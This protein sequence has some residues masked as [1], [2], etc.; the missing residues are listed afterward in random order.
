[1]WLTRKEVEVIGLMISL[2]SDAYHIAPSY[3][4]W[5]TKDRRMVSPTNPDLGTLV[6]NSRTISRNPRN[7]VR[8]LGIWIVSEKRLPTIRLES[9]LYF[10]ANCRFEGFE[11]RHCI[12]STPRNPLCSQLMERR[13]RGQ[14]SY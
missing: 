14:H 12:W 11:V 9:G 10:D 2:V 4:C 13:E 3:L 7:D 5:D 6:T 1:M 8:K